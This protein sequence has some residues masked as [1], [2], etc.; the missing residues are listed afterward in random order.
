[1]SEK[2]CIFCDHPIDNHPFRHPF[3]AG[4]DPFAVT[5]LRSD[6][7]TPGKQQGN[8]PPLPIDP[9]LRI[10][11][12]DKGILTT[13]DLA[14]AQSKVEI[15]QGPEGTRSTVIGGGI[16]TPKAEGSQ[17][18]DHQGQEKE[19]SPGQESAKNDS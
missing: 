10:A 12:I 11:L 19:R 4:D 7:G 1:M 9:V 8:A 16:R 13:D 5:S 18:E 2:L 6:P 3:T 17:P 15:V 14:Q